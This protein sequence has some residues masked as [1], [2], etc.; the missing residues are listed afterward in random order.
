MER[1]N[2]AADVQGDWSPIGQHAEHTTAGAFN[3]NTD[4]ENNDGELLAGINREL[5]KTNKNV[6]NFFTGVTAAAVACVR[7]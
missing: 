4:G 5:A 7:W 1:I 2:F 3:A 6:L